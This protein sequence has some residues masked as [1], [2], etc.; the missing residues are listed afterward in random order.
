[1]G[2]HARDKDAVVSSVIICE[3]AAYYKKKGKTLIDVIGEL[4]NE[5]GYYL[6]ALDS[7]TLKGIEGMEKIKSL[8]SYFRTEGKSLFANVTEVFD[9]AEGIDGLPK[10]DV[11]KFCFADGSWLAIRPSGTEPKIKVYYSVVGVNAAY[12]SE[13]LMKYR[14]IVKKQICEETF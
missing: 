7:F 3:M 14:D 6:D 2:T 9:Y 8:M 4:Y 12:S 1:M 13:L 10:S 11:L 5:Y